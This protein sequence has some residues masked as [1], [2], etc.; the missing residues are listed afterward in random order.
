MSAAVLQ[1]RTIGAGSTLSLSLAFEADVTDGSAIHVISGQGSNADVVY[2]WSDDNGGD[3]AQLGS[4]TFDSS[5]QQGI[6]HGCALDHAAGAT[7][8]TVDF[9]EAALFADLIVRE[10]GGV[11]SDTPVHA[12]S[13]LSTATTTPSIAATN[14]TQP[15]LWSAFAYNAGYGAITATDGTSG[16]S[17]D[18]NS[19]CDGLTASERVTS[20][21]SQ[22]ATFSGPSTSYQLV[23]AIFAEAGGGGGATGS[24]DITEGAD[25]VSG[26]GASSTAGSAAITEG[27]DSV[28]GSGATSTTGAAAITEGADTV[29]ASGAVGASGA[30]SI[31]EGSDSVVGT[32]ATSTGG[33]AAITEGHDTVDASGAQGAVGDAAIAEDADTVSGSGS[34]ATSGSAAIAEGHDRPQGSGNA[35][36]SVVPAGRHRR[37]YGVRVGERILLFDTPAQAQ[38]ARAALQPRSA[39]VPRHL[40][41]VP[42]VPAEIIDLPT[43]RALAEQQHQL[44]QLQTLESG[45]DYA[46]LAVFYRELQLREQLARST[47]R[48][49]QELAARE[50]LLQEREHRRALLQQLQPLLSLLHEYGRSLH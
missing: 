44:P 48:R 40:R 46:P 12:E 17:L 7:T 14:T 19:G 33:S 15:A 31:A 30:A 49:M 25:T 16:I 47:R 23:M 21:G 20:T 43:V 41:V 38:A 50:L 45:P 35:T 24:A 5:Q 27:H 6:A 34:T 26:A 3:Y 4:S 37:R 1:E 36:G 42:P 32:G 18:G 2:S 8:V 28:S 22:S 29:Q 39:R 11:T 9:G 13:L 10:I